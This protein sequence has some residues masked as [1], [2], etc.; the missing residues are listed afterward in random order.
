VTLTLEQLA[1]FGSS[2]AGQRSL[3]QVR[4]LPPGEEALIAGADERGWRLLRARREAAD[5]DWAGHY[6]TADAALEAL[7]R[8]LPAGLD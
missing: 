1:S 4:G 3:Y 8:T 7:L 6:P 2:R 5:D